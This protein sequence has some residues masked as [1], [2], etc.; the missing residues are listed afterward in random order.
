MFSSLPIRPAFPRLPF[1]CA[2]FGQ[3]D[4]SRIEV[5]QTPFYVRQGCGLYMTFQG[6]GATRWSTWDNQFIATFDRPHMAVTPDGQMAVSTLNANSQ[7]KY[8]IYDI[9]GFL[10]FGWEGDTT[11]YQTPNTPQLTSNGHSIFSLLTGFDGFGYYK[12][13][14]DPNQ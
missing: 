14:Y 3:P 1:F 13:L 5:A 4:R 11:G 9:E 8:G 6:L 7:P 10:M 12:Q 2:K